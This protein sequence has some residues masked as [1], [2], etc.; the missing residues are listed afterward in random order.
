MPKTIKDIIS[1]GD[2]LRNRNS[3][4][5]LRAFKNINEQIL[6]LNALSPELK[7][8]LEK[9]NKAVQEYDPKI[10]YGDLY[11]KFLNTLE[12]Q[13]PPLC[14]NLEKNLN[15][16]KY[17]SASEELARIDALIELIYHNEN[18]ALENAEKAVAE[19][20]AS[21]IQTQHEIESDITRHLSRGERAINQ[22]TPQTEGSNWG[23]FKAMIATDFKPQMTTSMASVRQYDH[24]KDLTSTELRFG[25]QGQRHEGTVRVSPLFELWLQQQHRKNIAQNDNVEPDNIAAITHVYINNLGLDRNDFE[26]KKER[27][28]SRALHDLE[29]R[30]PN[31]AVITLPAD[32]G[33][34]SKSMLE[35]DRKYSAQQAKDIC[36]IIATRG[37]DPNPA[38]DLSH[39]IEGDRRD[40]YISDKIK[41]LL[42]G[43]EGYEAVIERLV[44]KSFE[45]F[46][47][48]EGD[49]L[50]SAQL[51]AV[52][53]H[54]TKFEL[55]NHIQKTL[56]PQ[57]I[58]MSCKDAIDRG[59]VSSA[60]YNLMKSIEIGQPM[61]KS[62][63]ER[64]LHAAPTLVKGRG[65]NHHAKI[66][67]NAIDKYLDN[68]NMEGNIPEW[69][70]DWRLENCPKDK[71]KETLD[72]TIANSIVR[73]K[74]Q[75]S[76]SSDEVDK[77]LIQKAIETLEETQNL[78]SDAKP[79]AYGLLY[80]AALQTESLLN[81][82]IELRHAT[83]E[84]QA[85]KNK[86]FDNAFKRYKNLNETANKNYSSL[87]KVLT[88]FF[89]AIGS[90]FSNTVKTGYEKDKQ[91]KGLVDTHQKS[92]DHYKEI[93]AA[94]QQQKN[95]MSE[96]QP[97]ESD[98]HSARFT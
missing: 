5:Y 56:Q 65:M 53:F 20:V 19:I 67:W 23:R 83:P 73:L 47:F 33:I 31:V 28:L 72:K 10:P 81:K 95:A 66:I 4:E 86:A 75:L 50:S 88:K 3:Y 45:E 60:Y 59:G 55:T 68:K 2:S 54:F 39:L 58:N 9:V 34:M 21:T 78:S 69:L 61:S 30:H 84:N 37:E 41:R 74:D 29:N 90:V 77:A 91:A 42:G 93:K 35:Q 43:E 32:K 18:Q 40:F 63:F 7:D 1:T 80:Q 82:A 38:T 46:G 98:K 17:P 79:S 97:V 62:E 76:E 71:A 70:F 22:I 13:L 49:Q 8:I 48:K 94:Y 44:N 87:G 6:E 24:S 14:R 25:T 36:R 27:A 26:G 51:Q 96:E 64:A 57:T 52:F 15:N 92:I 11:T 12:E 16:E 89:K 85:D